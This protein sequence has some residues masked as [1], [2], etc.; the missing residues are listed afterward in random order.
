ML[1]E[2]RAPSLEFWA[3]PR[4]L[5]PK[6]TK[7]PT[8]SCQERYWYPQKYANTRLMFVAFQGGGWSLDWEGSR[9]IRWEF[10]TKGDRMA[11]PRRP[12]NKDEVLDDMNGRVLTASDGCL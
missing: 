3:K 5:A 2:G 9:C 7:R 1:S 10:N 6:N 8:D 11:K 4:V 12:A